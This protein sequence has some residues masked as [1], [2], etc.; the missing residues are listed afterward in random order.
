MLGVVMELNMQVPGNVVYNYSN[1]APDGVNLFPVQLIETSVF[2]LIFIYMIFKYKKKQFDMKAFS[3]SIILCG[4]AKFILDYFRMS[5]NGVVISKNQ[6]ISIIFILLGIYLYIKYLKEI[7]INRKV[8][9][10]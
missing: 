10:E 1:S 8:E 4:L 5:H 7:N 6:I 2:L 9:N 3:F